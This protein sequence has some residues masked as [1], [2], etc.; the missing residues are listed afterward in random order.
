MSGWEVWSANSGVVDAVFPRLQKLE[1]EFCPNLVEVSLEAL[2][3]LRVLELSGCGDGVLK[4]LIHAASSAT[5]LRISSIS[6]LSDEVWRGVMDY[7]G[8]VEELSI[9]RCNEIRYLWES[10]AEASKVLVNLRNLDVY[11]CSKLVSLGEKEEDGCN[12]LTSLRS[13]SI[14]LCG[15]LERCN[16]PNNIQDLSISFCRMIA[17][18]SF[19]AGGHKLKSLEIDGS[20]QL[21]I[22]S[23]ATQNSI[24]ELTCFI[25]LTYLRIEDCS[26]IELFPAAELPN[27]TSLTRLTISDCKSMDVD[28]F[29][30]WPPKF[31]SLEI[32]RLKKPISKW[33][34]QNFPPSLVHLKLLGGS[35]EEDDVTSGSQL[36]HMLPSSLTRLHLNGFKKLETKRQVEEAPIGPLSPISHMWTYAKGPPGSGKGT[37]SPII[38]DEYCL[39]HLATG[40]ML[41]A[42]V[43]AKTPLGIKAKEAMDNGQLVS[44]DLVVGII[45]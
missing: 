5:K 23:W 28:S 8:A 35:V 20:E 19:P 18:V 42:A 41:R 15:N 1:I 17:S 43:A 12:Q 38:K 4:S 10:E 24:N 11:D 16:L 3:S 30:L 9:W 40:D 13:L 6:G 44:D 25:Q 37:Q 36:S 21:K 45:D 32:G 39:C 31:G 7:L 34:P 14:Y 29:G 22:S 26:S 27:L 33:G 2:H